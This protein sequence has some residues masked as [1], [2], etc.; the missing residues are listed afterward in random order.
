MW[1]FKSNPIHLESQTKWSI[2]LR[3]VMTMSL[4][5]PFLHVHHINA[6]EVVTGGITILENVEDNDHGAHHHDEPESSHSRDHSHTFDNHTD[7][8]LFRPQSNNSSISDNEFVGPNGQYPW[9]SKRPFTRFHLAERPILG[10][11]KVFT[12]IIRGPPTL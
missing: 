7:W 12:S 3:L 8:K 10:I 6:A 9:N 4:L 1:K 11:L 2:L 5:S